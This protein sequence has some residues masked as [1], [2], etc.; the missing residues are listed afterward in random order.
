[1][2][3]YAKSC[4]WYLRNPWSICTSGSALFIKTKNHV[5]ACPL[6]KLPCIHFI[7]SQ[8]KQY[9]YKSHCFIIHFHTYT[10]VQKQIQNLYTT[11]V[12]T[13]GN[14]KIWPYNMYNIKN[15]ALICIISN[16]KFLVMKSSWTRRCI[17]PYFPYIFL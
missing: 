5:R 13:F 14:A 4:A 10:R 2:R 17:I 3:P 16:H 1:M 11:C 9:T 8:I 6:I 12:Q 7:F 15:M